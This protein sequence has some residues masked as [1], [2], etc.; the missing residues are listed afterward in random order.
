MRHS[1]LRGVKLAV[2]AVA[3]AAMMMPLT[4]CGGDDHPATADD[5]KPIVYI[6]V[7]RNVTDVHVKDMPF[8]QEP[9]TPGVSRRTPRWW[10]VISRTSVCRCST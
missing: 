3:A 7:R 5:G 2:A 9:T 4:A 6:T 1:S 8:T 10:P